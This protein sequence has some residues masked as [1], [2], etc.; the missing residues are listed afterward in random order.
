MAKTTGNPGGGEPEPSGP[1]ASRG[2]PSDPDASGLVPV[3]GE[4]GSPGAT[5]AA[6]SPGPDVSAGG[7]DDG[8]G[9]EPLADYGYD[10]GYGYGPGYGDPDG[11]AGYSYGPGYA[12]PEPT[13]DAGPGYRYPDD[14]DEPVPARAPQLAPNPTPP[15]PPPGDPY[16]TTPAA[17]TTG[18]ALAYR[19][20]APVVAA[21]PA[22]RGYPG[23][24]GLGGS[25]ATGRGNR[26]LTSP[27]VWQH[28]Q[29]AWR[30]SGVEWQRPADGWEPAEAEWDRV[31]TAPA[32]RSR[33]AGPVTPPRPASGAGKLSGR[34]P[35]R[36]LGGLS[37]A[38]LPGGSLSGS[39]VLRSARRGGGTGL[40]TGRGPW[41]GLLAVIVVAALVVGGLYL[42]GPLGNSGAAPRARVAGPFPAAVPAAAD[43]TV[44]PAG[45]GRGIFQSIAAT[46]AS[47]HTVVAAGYETGQW[48][49][50]AQF[51]VSVNGG[52]AWRLAPVTT[53]RGVTPALSAQ[54]QLL[55]GG[56][57]GWLA[58]GTGAVWA[59]KDGTAWTLVSGTGIPLRAG[60]HLTS[61]AAAGP[62]WL[63]IGSNG[64]TPV[65]WT[66]AAGRTWRRLSGAALQLP[67]TGGGRVVSLSSV[68]AHGGNVL[69]DGGVLTQHKRTGRRGRRRT[70]TTHTM[71][72]WASSDGGTTWTAANPPVSKGVS[73]WVDGVA[74]TGSGFVAIR[75]GS[76]KKSGTD[77][78]VYT[79]STGASWTQSA[80]LTAGKKAGLHIN[81]VSGSDQGAVA[82]GS[83][84]NGT[85]V[86]YL[87]SDGS[88]WSS[89]P[90]LGS[91][92]ETLH[93]VTVTAG[94]AV[95]A[96]G[97][98]PASALRQQPWLVLSGSRASAAQPV[99][100][101]KI[102]GAA[103]P[104]LGVTGLAV[105]AGR[106]V[107]VGSANGFPAIW[108]AAGRGRRS[109]VTPAALTSLSG[110]GT[111]TSVTHGHAGWV[112]VGG[113]TAAAP[114]QPVVVT[115]PDGT[116]WQ[117]V[118]PGSVF[119]GTGITVRQAAAGPSGYVVVGTQDIPAHR[120]TVTRTVRHHKR[121]VSRTVAA[122]SY[123]AAWFS[124][125]LTGW[126]RATGQLSGT[127]GHPQLAAVT[128]GGPGYVAV[129]SDGGSPA[130]WTSSTGQQWTETQ[131]AGPSGASSAAL[132]NVAAHGKVLVATGT[133]TAAS[134]AT[135][136]FTLV[137][138]DGGTQWH[139]VSLPRP[140][141]TSASA[142]TAVTA[143][144]AAGRAGFTAV[145]TLGPPGGQRVV[146]WTSADGRSWRAHEPS[147]T[148]LDSP[149]SQALTA[150]AVSGSQL[151]GVGYLA[152]PAGEEP[153]LWRGSGN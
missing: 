114:A 30:E 102:P 83:L 69:V 81:E 119:N 137:S 115:S 73:D 24:P 19:P 95:V 46:A 107:A 16:A 103:Q 93:G 3:S 122:R 55:A 43:F 89:V 100:F 118:T 82:A 47:G 80:T 34:L 101:A 96:G 145:G 54:P 99:D 36:T 28:A 136:P 91:T 132:L 8:F 11:G 9:G 23:G 14:D 112:A 45:Q 129:G 116:T 121:K 44:S 58:V 87:S 22:L 88:T 26:G 70:V 130:V 79:S 49:P 31:Q 131:V 126:T 153:T 113:V 12:A 62:G 59:S 53:A 90:S 21:T 94:P 37:S 10:G 4:S 27:S 32:D 127:S 15:A 68:A 72:V 111:L 85:R 125:G 40:R 5:G 141:H 6:G 146:F 67:T 1:G 123:A 120:V 42:F 86:A 48:L 110:L 75:P 65:L 135:A 117:P 57:D 150:L 134:G 64:T 105:A 71:G 148:G 124:T 140:A 84:A 33:G 151:A 128:A 149:G 74:A 52:Q 63:A 13:A 92:A 41:V 56:P 60:D 17:P 18:P 138:T 97:S 98:G 38:A 104:A 147:G 29:Q 39:S 108:S 25:T 144:A 35:S 66:S 50:R 152:T 51:L 7:G 139:Q 133:Q 143:L 20:L 109:Q 77:A 76:T 2:G 142:L 106:Q 61:L 78:V